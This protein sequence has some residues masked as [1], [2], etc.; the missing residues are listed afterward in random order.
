MQAPATCHW[1]Y[2]VVG[3]RTPVPLVTTFT[4]PSSGTGRGWDP[5]Y[6][7]QRRLWDIKYCPPAP[8]PTTAPA[9]APPTT[10]PQTTPPPP[11]P[12]ASETP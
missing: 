9:P 1:A 2:Y 6:Y 5:P 3:D 11:P 10:P 8:P 12:T 4:A 7:L